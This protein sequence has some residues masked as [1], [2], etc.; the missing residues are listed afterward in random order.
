M[1]SR[2]RPGRFLGSTRPTFRCSFRLTAIPL[3]TVLS[4]D[5]TGKSALRQ[6]L[7]LMT[8]PMVISDHGHTIAIWAAGNLLAFT[9]VTVSHSNTTDTCKLPSRLPTSKTNGD[10]SRE[11]HNSLSRDVTL[12]NKFSSPNDCRKLRTSSIPPVFWGGGTLTKSPAFSDP[13]TPVK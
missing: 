11:G 5:S 8:M 4:Y 12:S 1:T 2:R 6:V 9:M 7:A 13:L 3:A 10:T